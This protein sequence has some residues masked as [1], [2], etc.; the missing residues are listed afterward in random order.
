MSTQFYVD[1][2][3][4][5]LELLDE[6]PQH[7]N[8]TAD[9]M[10]W[11]TEEATLADACGLLSALAYHITIPNQAQDQLIAAVLRRLVA[12]PSLLAEEAAAG[13]VS[14]AVH[15]YRQLGPGSIARHHLLRL[16]AL[17]GEDE[18]SVLTDLLV[19]DPPSE[20]QEVLL[21][22]AP[23]FQRQ[24]LNPEAL[25]P[26]MLDAVRHPSV[27]ASV[28]DLAN[29]FARSDLVAEHPA[30]DRAT[31]LIGLL[32]ELTQ[33]LGQLEERV[34]FE[35]DG[36]PDAS[37]SAR[38]VEDSVALAVSLCHA[39]ALIG[40]RAAVGKLYQAL[41]LRHRR[42]RTEAAAALARF[43]EKAGF[44][45]LAAMAS[46]PV[47]RLRVLAYADELDCLD[48]IDPQYQT[49]QSRGEAE[50]ALWLAQPTQFGI[51]PSQL[52]VVDSRDLYWPGYED[53][54]SC[55]LF[56]FTYRL[57]DGEYSNIGIAGPCVH[58]FAAD[59]ADLPPDDIYA[60][61]AGWQVEHEDIYETDVARLAAGTQP[62]VVRLERRMRDEGY[63]LVEPLSLGS[64]FGSKSL[65]AR[66]QRE[67]TAGI[68]VVDS[69][70]CQWHPEVGARPIDADLAYS[71]YKGRRLMRS[72]NS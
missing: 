57:A 21:V 24:D 34:G 27:A 11:L 9:G 58:A 51:P 7:T 22:F 62:E 46:E 42:L 48:D 25:F 16:L 65:V 50:L 54:V 59:L 44:E 66:G 23:L 18:L 6:H 67:G 39:L 63:Q 5:Q 47:A 31:R 37:S 43:D 14:S 26:R 20:S 35:A 45:T 69:G 68:V 49:S 8:F 29:F 15:L 2:I 13:L 56:R 10:S 33:R 70:F 28:I 30:A 72:F 12:N 40:N 38:T 52:E 17:R 60:A 3:L 41:D 1:Q 64:F 71:I 53:E 36:G 19:E 4:T 55:F 61:F 32:G